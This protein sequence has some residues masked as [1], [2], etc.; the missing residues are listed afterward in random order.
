MAQTAS[1]SRVF[2][3]TCAINSQIG[4]TMTYGNAPVILVIESDETTRNFLI[5]VLHWAG[6]AVV[7]ATTGSQALATVESR[8]V[9]LA[10]SASHL[11]GL[12]GAE[13]LQKLRNREARHRLSPIPF[14][15]L[16]GDL[17]LSAVT[18][19]YRLAA[20]L[21][22]GELVSAVSAMLIIA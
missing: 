18:R 13:V 2:R 14:I 7:A 19:A 17:D 8:V 20:P 12:N 4:R 6:F 11:R 1:Q 10:I 21:N 22:V 3:A 5:E 16:S 15:M 9:S